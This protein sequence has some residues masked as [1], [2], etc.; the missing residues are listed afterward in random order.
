MSLSLRNVL[1]MLDSLHL[2]EGT[3]EGGQASFCQ[4]KELAESEPELRPGFPQRCLCVAGWPGDDDD[5]A[6]WEKDSR[7]RRLG[8]GSQGYKCAGAP[9]FPGAQERSG[10]SKVTIL[11]PSH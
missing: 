2:P 4:M 8:L 11:A 7:D 10:E 5:F 3:L 9:K 6:M 1:N